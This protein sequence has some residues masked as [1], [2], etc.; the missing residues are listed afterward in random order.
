MVILPAIDLIGGRCVRLRQGDFAQKTEYPED[1]IAAAGRFAEE[2]AQWLHVVD[3]EGAKQGR[4]TPGHLEIVRR[5]AASTGL[6]VQFGGGIQAREAVDAALQAGAERFVLGTALI[7][8]PGL[9]EWCFGHH[10]DRAVGGIDCRNGWVAVS[11]WTETSCLSAEEV[12]R[13]VAEFGCRRLVVTDIA[14]D[15]MLTGPNV[16]LLTSVHA[17]SGLRL[18]ASGGVSSLEDFVRLRELGAWLEGV[19]VGKA[20]HEGRISLSEAIALVGSPDPGGTALE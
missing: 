10:P 14:T 12:A 8:D 18:I 13:S 17:A 9:A 20:I 7:R 19:I 6:R 15:G 3:L 2:G 4:P 11:G 16:D 5:I 1:P